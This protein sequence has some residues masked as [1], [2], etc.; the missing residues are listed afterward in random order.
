MTTE[1]LKAQAYDAMVQVE[2]W[3]RK[4]Q[5]LNRQ[6]AEAIKSEKSDNDKPIAK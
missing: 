4:L 6:I 5:E 2:V 1:E 3:Q